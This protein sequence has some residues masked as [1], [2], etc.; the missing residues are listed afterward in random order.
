MPTASPTFWWWTT[1]PMRGSSQNL[2]GARYADYMDKREFRRAIA[3]NALGGG[4]DRGDP[5]PGRLLQHAGGRRRV[6]D[7]Q[8]LPVH[9]G[10]VALCHRAGRGAGLCL[11]CGGL[12]ALRAGTLHA[13]AG[14]R[15]AAECL[16]I[17]EAGLRPLLPQSA[18]SGPGADHGGRV[19]ATSMCTGRASSTRG[20]WPR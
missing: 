6:H 16:R 11:Q 5:A 13:D 17:L 10:G 8:Q 3:E 14:E 9:Q 18:G 7:G 15:A 20:A 2:H 4:Q 12:W 19:C 1:W